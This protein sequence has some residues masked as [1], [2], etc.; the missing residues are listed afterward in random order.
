MWGCSREQ[1]LCIVS[2]SVLFYFLPGV[3][4][5]LIFK[6][7]KRKIFTSDSGA[8]PRLKT[9]LVVEKAQD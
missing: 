2:P 4:I 3:Y 7:E 1:L 6:K 5:A 9:T 8:Q